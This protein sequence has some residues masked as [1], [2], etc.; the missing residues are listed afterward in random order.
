M[1]SAHRKTRKRSGAATVEFASILPVFLLF[2]FGLVEVCYAQMVVNLLKTATRA[3][4]RT[5]SIEGVTTSQVMGIV[6]AKLSPVVDSDYITI[7]VKNAGA[8]DSESSDLPDSSDEFN[9]LDDIE[10]EDAEPRQLFLVRATVNYN[11]ISLL[12]L[13]YTQNLVLTGQAFM[14]HE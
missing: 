13:P 8:W 7:L 6:Q 12:S 9:D 3:A 4:A 10:L 14:R 2:I 5:G 11:Q 1:K